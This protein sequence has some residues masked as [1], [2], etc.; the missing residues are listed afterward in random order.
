[1][2]EGFEVRLSPR[3]GETRC[4]YCHGDFLEGEPTEECPGC[5]AVHH[6][7]CYRDPRACACC[8]RPT[9]V[10]AP[11]RRPRVLALGRD[12]GAL[13]VAST[14]VLAMIGPLAIASWQ[15]A[16]FVVLTFVATVAISVLLGQLLEAFVQ[17]VLRLRARRRAARRASAP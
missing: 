15:A 13:I 3:P 17:R 5:H 4:P 10:A 2:T 7:R 16:L 12:H 1:M 9:D 11:A 6:R 8:A 14:L